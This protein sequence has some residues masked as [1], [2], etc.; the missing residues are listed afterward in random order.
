MKKMFSGY[1][2][3]IEKRLLNCEVE[4]KGVKLTK[5][6]LEGLKDYVKYDPVLKIA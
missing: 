6:Q 1:R 4:L 5:W 2:D 3:L